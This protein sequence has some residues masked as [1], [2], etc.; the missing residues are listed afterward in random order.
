M[1][2]NRPVTFAQTLPAQAPV[3][4]P[5]SQ[6]MFGASTPKF[7]SNATE[8]GGE[9]TGGK[10]FFNLL[11]RIFDR[12]TLKGHKNEDDKMKE[13]PIPFL[14]EKHNELVKRQKTI[15]VGLSSVIGKADLAKK[16]LEEAKRVEEKEKKEAVA[17]AQ[18][19]KELSET[20]ADYAAQR[21][22]AELQATEWK[23][24]KGKTA[25]KQELLE[26]LDIEAQS[27]KDQLAEVK[28]QVA[29]MLD[30][31]DKAAENHE[32]NELK[33]Q[34][35]ATK[36]EI[37]SLTN[38]LNFTDSATSLIRGIEEE[39]ATLDVQ[40][41]GGKTREERASELRAKHNAKKHE[42]SAALDELLAETETKPAAG[43]Q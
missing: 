41:S 28:T 1:N 3:Q 39:S 17:A 34:I 42:A 31:I 30:Q 36:E 8:G 13:D 19:M 27:A 14:T 26:Q 7:G 22:Y 9:R 21:E 43:E 35:L 38:G 32:R 2:V 40:L 20:D 10:G 12:L 5:A 29:T 18:A 37:D 15:E 16:D 24:A 4:A 23:E 6:P 33:K 11:R 25:E